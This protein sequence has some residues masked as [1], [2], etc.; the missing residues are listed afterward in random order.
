R[1]HGRAPAKG[2]RPT[3]FSEADDRTRRFALVA[4]RG[5]ERLVLVRK[6][7]YGEAQKR[8]YG[9]TQGQMPSHVRHRRA[10]RRSDHPCRRLKDR[11]R[12]TQPGSPPPGAGKFTSLRR[13]ARSSWWQ[14]AFDDDLTG[15]ATQGGLASAT[16][17][18]PTLTFSAYP[19]SVAPG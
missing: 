16:P 12:L 14:V 4:H 18:A 5:T 15:W 10:R 11:P 7:T 1:A 3:P 9:R 2:R 19:P 8:A 6:R 17:G 13:F